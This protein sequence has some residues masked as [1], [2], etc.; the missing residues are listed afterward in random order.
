MPKVIDAAAGA[1][2]R[3]LSGAAA[4]L[5]SLRPAAK[6]LHPEG[7]LYRGR[8]TRFG[9]ADPIGVPWIDEPGVDDVLVRLSRAVGLPGALP[10]V[11]GMA[12]RLTLDDS[13]VGDVLLATTGWNRLAR[14]VLTFGW[15]PERPMS[16]LL[17]YRTPAGPVVLGARPGTH[18]DFRLCWARAGHSWRPLGDLVLE[19]GPDPDRVVSFDPVLNTVPG[20]DQYSWVVQLRER[21]YATA[22][23][24]RS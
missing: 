14:H 23:E 10:D 6:P 11:H 19:D 3:V 12:L 20:L 8:L 4:T 18:A 17:P 5:A 16:T 22:R 15:S 21:A 13:R 9:S 7:T 1:A 2:G 24:H